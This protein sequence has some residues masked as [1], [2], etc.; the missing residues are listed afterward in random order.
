MNNTLLT[1]TISAS[2]AAS[3]AACADRIVVAPGAD[4]VHITEAPADVQ[5]CQPVGNVDGSRTGGT[6]VMLGNVV[7]G[8]GGDTLL[9]TARGTL[10]G[11]AYRCAKGRPSDTP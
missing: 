9:M 4:K 6:P 8:L 11:V 10:L 5:G 2:L 7:V 3:L 1:L